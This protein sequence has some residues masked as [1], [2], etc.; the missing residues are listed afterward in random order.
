[1]QCSFFSF[2]QHHPVYFHYYMFEDCI[3]TR[4]H[5]HSRGGRRR[6]I[7]IPVWI[8]PLYCIPTYIHL[9]LLQLLYTLLFL[10]LS[11]LFTISLAGKLLDSWRCKGSKGVHFQQW[12]WLGVGKT[13]PCKASPFLNGFTSSYL[14]FRTQRFS[15]LWSLERF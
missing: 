5:L 7:N 12:T 15:N 11:K 6:E 2:V 4:N 13:I 10:W 3:G 14:F 1:M 9:L 8:D